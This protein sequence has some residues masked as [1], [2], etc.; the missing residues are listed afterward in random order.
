MHPRRPESKT[1]KE[2]FERVQLGRFVVDIMADDHINFFSI[3]E[4]SEPRSSRILMWKAGSG[5]RA[6]MILS[7][8]ASSLEV[9]KPLDI[10]S[11]PHAEVTALIRADQNKFTTRTANR[12]LGILSSCGSSG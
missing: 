1:L 12:L 11:F 3:V 9:A 4:Q 10:Q 7:D 6:N 5:F 2:Q 8:E